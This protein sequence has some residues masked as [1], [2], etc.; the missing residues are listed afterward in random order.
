M[1][2]PSSTFD[3][4]IDAVLEYLPATERLW[5]IYKIWYNFASFDFKPWEESKYASEIKDAIK[6]NNPA[7]YEYLIRE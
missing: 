3:T 1:N 7:L 6:Q 2:V 5:V 4:T